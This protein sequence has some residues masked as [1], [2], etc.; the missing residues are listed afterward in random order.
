MIYE[1]R[2]YV[3]TVERV[4]ALHRRFAEQTLP[5]FA[6]LG[7]EVVGFFTDRGDPT[8]IVYLTRFPDEGARTAA[9]AAFADDAEWRE[10]KERSE[11]DG[12]LVVERESVVLEPTPYSPVR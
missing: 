7:I 5:I 9:W 10:V 1:L 4:D 8:R 11:R 6:R 2:S 3:S 12:A